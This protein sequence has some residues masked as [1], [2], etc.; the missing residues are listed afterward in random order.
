L[1]VVYRQPS[2]D[3]GAFLD[4]LE[5]Y[6]STLS[7]LNHIIAGDINIDTLRNTNVCSEYLN[8]LSLANFHHAIRIPTRMNACLDHINLNLDNVI[9]SSGTI[10][11]AISDHTPTF[12]CLQH[13]NVAFSD[14]YQTLLFRDYKLFAV[15][16]FLADL[17]LTD[18][19]ELVY[20]QVDVNVMYENFASTFIKICDKH[21]PYKK[22]NVNAKGKPFRKPW[23]TPELLRLMNKRDYIYRQTLNNPLNTK[24][25]SKLK[26]IRNHVTSSVRNAKSEYFEN[27]LRSTTDSS[28]YWNVI[29][30]NTG[31]VKQNYSSPKSII[32]EQNEEL[33]DDLSIAN[34]LNSYFTSIGQKLASAF[35]HDCPSPD[36]TLPVNSTSLGSSFIFTP[37]DQESLNNLFDS[38]D[39]RKATGLDSI[40]AKL[41]KI[42]RPAIISPLLFIINYSFKSRVFPDSLKIAK[43]IPLFKKGCTKSCKNYRP[44]SILSTFSKLFERAANK[45]ISNFLEDNKMIVDNQF[46][47][48]PNRSTTTALISLTNTVLSAFDNRRALLGIFIDFSK[49]FDTIDHLILIQK[50]E[51]FNFSADA[52]AW[53]KSYLTNRKQVT[54]INKTFSQFENVCIGVPQ[55]SILGPTLF[56]LYIND[57]VG[58]V[59]KFQPILYA[60]D[61]NLFYESDNLDRDVHEI[62]K[63][64]NSIEKWCVKNKLTLNT[65][66]T[67]YI[68]LKNYQSSQT[69]TPNTL[70]IFNK[71][72]SEAESI[73]FLGVY[74][75]KTL[76]WKSHI[77]NLCERIRPMVGALY[78]CSKF[79]PK[80]VLILIYN[81]LV[82]SKL[83][84]CIEAWGKTSD[85]NLNKLIVYQ[86]KIIRIIFKKRPLSHT[87]ELF[88]KSAI[89]SIEK[90]YKFRTLLYAHSLFHTSTVHH[91]Q[92]SHYTR[93]SIINLSLPSSTTAAGHRRTAF[94]CA[95]L[96]NNLPVAIRTQQARSVFR[97][98]L[99][100]HLLES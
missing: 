20:G 33:S 70:T 19:N 67:Y 96:W 14:K 48:R 95:A 4:D 43:V 27:L 85:S 29:N 8:I 22:V 84:Y 42:A 15:D 68:V 30:Q 21:A 2:A 72:I 31:R 64:L 17:H 93:S 71:P 81:A 91:V 60:D 44:I 65:D 50:L 9:V 39:P 75:D 78:R 38:F 16:K 49:A 100:A 77:D 32:N 54:V 63:E 86:K 26:R 73:K 89:L 82:N 41:V 56:L 97:V 51:Q 1:T 83:N 66:K 34:C 28:K 18:W 59:T 24:L 7:S 76:S 5:Q 23:I 79:L 25:K 12:L 47:F 80:K 13:P 46:G 98:G 58:V 10:L 52:I 36:A 57:L 69:L 74:I 99:R 94:Q 55:G 37:L 87:L 45:Q 88:K 53:I 3:T 35:K 62:N 6:I 11:T 40:P 92:H 61:T 90:L